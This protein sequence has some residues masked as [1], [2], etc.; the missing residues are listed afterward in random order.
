MKKQRDFR[1]K[2]SKVRVEQNKIYSQKLIKKGYL[3]NNEKGNHLFGSYLLNF[4]IYYLY[5]IPTLVVIWYDSAGPPSIAALI[6][7]FFVIVIC[8]SDRRLQ[9]KSEISAYLEENKTGIIYAY[10]ILNKVRENQIKNLCTMAIVYAVGFFGY[11]VVVYGDK[12]D[13]DSIP[14]VLLIMKMLLSLSVI[15]TLYD[16]WRTMNEGM[17]LAVPSFYI[18]K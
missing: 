6:A 10:D 4:I 5:V 9:K 14:M 3:V 8:I 1:E 15:A 17:F 18:R 7:N 12:V 16:K 2:F 11:V 13:V